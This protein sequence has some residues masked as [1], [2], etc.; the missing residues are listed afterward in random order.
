V[1]STSYLPREEDL[2][3]TSFAQGVFHERAAAVAR[4][5]CVITEKRVFDAVAAEALKP[6]RLGLAQCY[7]NGAAKPAAVNAEVLLV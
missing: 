2:T 3:S 1:A 4:E 6:A 5:R 7:R